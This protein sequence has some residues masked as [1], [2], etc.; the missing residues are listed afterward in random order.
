[1]TGLYQFLKKYGVGIGFGVGTLLAFLT[2]LFI[3]IGFPEGQPTKKE[4]YEY[5]IFD[6]GIISS[7]WLVYIAVFLVLVFFIKQAVEDPQGSIKPLAGIG[8]L[9]LTLDMVRSNSDLI[10]EGEVF[11]AGVTT[12][13]D[14]AFSDG[15]IKFGYFMLGT[16]ILS[17]LL[18]LVYGVV[19]Q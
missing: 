1:M 17:W 3:L 19:K 13:E 12:S 4:L 16:A 9:V 10:P 18:G 5:N 6:F 11:E 2:Y 8:I 7:Q 15:L 14:V